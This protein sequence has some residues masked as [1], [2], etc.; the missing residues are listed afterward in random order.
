MKFD[1]VIVGAG[2]S[3][4]T[5][6]ERVANDMGK[7]V[8]VIEKR[9]HIG[10][11][12]YDYFD[13]RGLLVHKYGP[14]IFHT[15]EKNVWDYLNAFTR[16]DC[17]Q[18]RVLSYVDGQYMPMPICA[19]TV[20]MLY[21][22][23]L[24][25]DEVADFLRSRADTD[26][27]VKSSED[28][29]LKAAGNLIYEKFFKHYSKKQWDVYPDELDP[30]V[31]SRVGVRTNGDDRYFTDKYQGMPVGGYTAMF[32][33][34]IKSDKIAVMTGVDYKTVLPSIQYDKL[35]YTG[36]VDYYFDYSVGVLKY[37]GVRFEFETVDTADYQ[38]ASVVNYPYEYDFTRITEYK[39]LTGQKHDMTIISR[40]YPTDEGEP[41]YPFPSDKWKRMYGEYEK[42]ANAQKNVYFVGRL[43]EYRYYNMDAAVKSALETYARM[44]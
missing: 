6:A 38:R 22:L 37:R 21:G 32:K 27:E 23:N 1:Y 36:P 8:L 16:F 18:H 10:G 5:I 39:K 12:C 34:M 41:C 19:K 15:N 4:L 2:I 7:S 29:V 40:E 13:E 9:K 42:L 31:I 28:V 33:N 14:H 11:N 43:A 3:G 26:R 17:Y 24:T 20:N 30:S 25:N 44:I 35:V